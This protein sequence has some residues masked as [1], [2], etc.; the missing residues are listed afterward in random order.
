VQG[1]RAGRHGVGK[2]SIDHQEELFGIGETL[3]GGCLLQNHAIH[4][5]RK[6]YQDFLGFSVRVIPLKSA[7][8]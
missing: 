3:C 5:R 6:N 4:S 7:H 1:Y 8:P 2:F